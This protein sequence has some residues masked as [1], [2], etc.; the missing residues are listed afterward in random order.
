MPWLSYFVDDRFCKIV[1]FFLT[2]PIMGLRIN[3]IQVKTKL[4]LLKTKTVL[5][6][7]SSPLR[8]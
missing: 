4:L 2:Y 5:S 8:F 7:T 3:S 6:F 1:K